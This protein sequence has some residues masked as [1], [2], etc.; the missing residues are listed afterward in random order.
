LPALELTADWQ[1]E[2]IAGRSGTGPE[3]RKLSKNEASLLTLDR[4]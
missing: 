3:G 1:P 4:E 2:F